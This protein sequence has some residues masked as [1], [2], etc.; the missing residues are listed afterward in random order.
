M[1]VTELEQYDAFGDIPFMAPYII[2]QAGQS[3]RQH[4]IVAG[5]RSSRSRRSGVGNRNETTATTT[6][7]MTRTTFIFIATNRTKASWVTSMLKRPN[8]GGVA[9]RVFYELPTCTEDK[10]DN[11]DD[12]NPRVV[13]HGGCMMKTLEPITA[14]QWGTVYD[15]HQQ[16]LRE[17]GIPT[18]DL[19]ATTARKWTVLCDTVAQVARDWKT[20]TTST[21]GM[22]THT[23]GTVY[24]VCDTHRRNGTPWPTANNTT[25]NKKGRKKNMKEKKTDER[26]REKE[27][28]RR[29]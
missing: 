11:E 12:Q 19:E 27:R 9:F 17:Y 28:R 16:L 4:A 20:M 23:P 26:S 8:K 15:G 18:L 13:N 22:S 5:S 10:E 2:A 1:L 3:V 25:K 6:S 24:T 14:D 29:R 21:T 7:S